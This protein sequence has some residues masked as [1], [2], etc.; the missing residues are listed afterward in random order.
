MIDRCLATLFLVLILV[1]LSA[2]DAHPDS[3]EMQPR[4]IG[5]YVSSIKEEKYLVQVTTAE[6]LCGG[7]LIKPRWVITAAH[8]VYNKTKDDFKVY[9]GASNQ[10][11]PYAIIRTVDFMAIR[12]DFNHKTLNMDVAA[13]RLSSDMIGANIETIALAAQSVPARAVVKVSGWGALNADTSETAMRVHSVLVPMWSRAS[14]VSAFR[15]KHR[16][17]RSMVCAAKLYKRDSCD[18]DSGGP[19][20]Y[21]GQLA[22]IVSFGYGCA[23]ALPG[24]Y[25]S[26]PVIRKWFLRVVEEHS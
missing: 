7:S 1:F 23:S 20:V 16:I 15:G 13:L 21:R 14:C 18:G 22:G 4:I 10:G 3:V 17:T 8:C 11:G 2:S 24:I 9:G 19:L 6:E 12:P 5:G 26:V 25:T